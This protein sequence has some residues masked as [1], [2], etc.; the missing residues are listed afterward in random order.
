M[1]AGRGAGIEERAVVCRCLRL[2]E[3][4][5]FTVKPHPPRTP[6][7]CKRHCEAVDGQYQP[8]CEPRFKMR[9]IRHRQPAR[10]PSRRRVP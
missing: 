8:I 1:R 5:R 6:P 7:E 3:S 4:S 2:A 9:E 10:W